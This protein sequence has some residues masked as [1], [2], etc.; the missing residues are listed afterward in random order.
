[1]EGPEQVIFGFAI[2]DFGFNRN[3]KSKVPNAKSYRM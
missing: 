2:L 1:M 3:P